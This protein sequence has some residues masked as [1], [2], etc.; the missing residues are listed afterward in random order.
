METFTAQSGLTSAG[1]FTTG[2]NAVNHQADAMWR[3]WIKNEA[4]AVAHNMV[5][6]PQTHRVF[7]TNHYFVGKRV[8]DDNNAND[9]MIVD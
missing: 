6:P 9:L 2:Q 5:S 4:T 8:Y 1:P 7:R 3:P